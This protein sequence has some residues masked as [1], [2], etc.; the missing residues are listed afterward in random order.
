VAYTARQTALRR[1]RAVR[2]DGRPCRAWACWDDAEQRC[3]AHNG[4]HHHGPEGPDYV[5]KPPAKRRVCHC[6]AYQWPHRPTSGP[7]RWPDLPLNTSPILPSTHAA[8]RWRDLNR[9]QRHHQRVVDRMLRE[10]SKFGR[11]DTARAP[12]QWHPVAYG[13]S[14]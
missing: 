10:A 9:A 11:V 14:G 2:Q 1:C 5:R 13:S 12:A 7:C 3:Q 8:V 4:R 6:P